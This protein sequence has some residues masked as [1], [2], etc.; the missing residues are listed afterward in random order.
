[1]LFRSRSKHLGMCSSKKKN[2]NINLYVVVRL[3]SGLY[4]PAMP[5]SWPM[6]LG[7]F[8]S[9]VIGALALIFVQYC[10]YRRRIGLGMI[11]T[12]AVCGS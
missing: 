11:V 6:W 3:L 5:F 2:A 1:M 10:L 12:K 4:L 8:L 7:V 9:M